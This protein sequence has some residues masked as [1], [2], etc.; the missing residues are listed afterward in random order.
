MRPKQLFKLTIN[1]EKRDVAA[2]GT[3]TLLEVL[4]EDVGLSAR[5]MVVKWVNAAP[6][7]CCSMVEVWVRRTLEEAA[8]RASRF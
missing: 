2:Y 7:Q 5:S 8:R 1:G 6:A 3:R 4:R